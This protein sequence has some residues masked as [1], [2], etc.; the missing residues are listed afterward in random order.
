MTAHVCADCG[1]LHDMPTATE[2]AAVAIA[3]I[4]AENR[5]AIAKLETR[6]DRHIADVAAETAEEIAEVEADAEVVAAAAEAEILGAAIEA[7][8]TDPAEIIVAPQ[9]VAE[10][11]VEDAPPPAEGSEPPVKSNKLGLGAW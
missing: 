11:T 9:A 8:D 2:D 6:T 1:L 3:R 10:E 5:L 7:S 4:E